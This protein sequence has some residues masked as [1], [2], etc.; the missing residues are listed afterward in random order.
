MKLTKNIL[1]PR[2]IKTGLATFLTALFCQ[3]V[4]LP[5][6]FAVITS[7]VSIEPTAKASLNKAFVRFP[8]SILG[9]FIAVT[10]TYFLGDSPLSYSLAATVTIVVCHQ[11][12]LFD[13]MLVASLTAVAMVPN[14][15]DAFAFNFF[16]RLLTT[17]IGLTT[18]GLVN[19]FVLPARYQPQIKALIDAVEVQSKQLFI[20]RGK[21]ALVGNF[22][23]ELSM[24]EIH[25]MN[26]LVSKI[27]KLIQY[28][29]EETQYHQNI[30]RRTQMT[31]LE[32]R[33]QINRLII[34]HLTNMIYLPENQTVSFTY[35]ERT[36]YVE[37][38]TALE[39]QQAVP[40]H[41]LST[42]KSSVK[43][44]SEF[45]DNQM[46]S[47]YIYELLMIQKLWQT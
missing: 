33:L 4:H 19:F 36:A 29:H 16:S 5:A 7:I 31:A 32:H 25:R 13:G 40:K 26:Q 34:I 24:N 23:S 39:T 1:G 9:A 8:A 45:D 47:H 28:E 30:E 37:L 41:A 17:S 11:L 22:Y 15:H 12:K 35:E 3:M 42:F 18:A 14:I 10:S 27:E 6:I 44:L 20:L 38:L 21:E 2:I 43:H 46:K